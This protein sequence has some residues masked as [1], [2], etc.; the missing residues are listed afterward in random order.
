MGWERTIEDYGKG[1]RQLRLA[2]LA[3]SVLV[4]IYGLIAAGM[5]IR[6]F[7][8]FAENPSL[9]FLYLYTPYL[10]LATGVV[11]AGFLVERWLNLENVKRCVVFILALPFIYSALRFPIEV[12]LFGFPYYWEFICCSLLSTVLLIGYAFLLWSRGRDHI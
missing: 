5:R 10:F 9:L 12:V 8:G 7:S 2:F 11:A 1:A 4:L 3:A 6:D